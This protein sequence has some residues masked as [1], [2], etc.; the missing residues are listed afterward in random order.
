MKT[1]HQ[2]WEEIALLIT[3]FAG[4]T[5]PSAWKKSKIDAFLRDFHKKLAEICRQEPEKAALCGVAVV[6]GET[7]QY[8]RLSYFSFR[9]IFITKESLG[10]RST[11]EMF[12]IYL[13]FESANDFLTRKGIF[14]EPPP[15][16]EVKNARHFRKNQLGRWMLLAILLIIIL[17][18]L[19]TCT[20]CN[21]TPSYMFVR[22]ENG[23]VLVNL[24]TKK[25]V[26]LVKID[27]LIGIDYDS[28][29]RMF[30]WTDTKPWFQSIGC[31]KLNYTYTDTEAGTMNTRLSEG[32]DTPVGIALDFQKQI[33]YCGDYERRTVTAYDLKGKALPEVLDLT[34]DGK[35][36]SVELDGKNRV[37][38][39]TDVENNRIGRIF[40]DDGRIEPRFIQLGACYP[41]GLSVDTLHDKIYWTCQMATELG[42]SY[43]ASPQIHTIS[44]KHA[45]AAV[46]VDP[47]HGALYYCK[48]SGDTI[49]KA[50]LP[51]D[52][53]TT[54]SV[55][56]SV[57]LEG[58]IGLGVMKIVHGQ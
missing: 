21:S 42:W 27:K 51:D 1:L 26:Q 22:H 33:I 4:G 56:D 37:L 48:K 12:A 54:V 38:Y 39:W 30:Y 28:E 9:R 24:E 7:V 47:V 41:D 5:H 53:Q 34:I 15:M 3:G 36:S 23:I 49:Y 8:P 29:T 57:V 31:A 11:R 55:I 45:V 32:M 58:M 6:N 10:N 50:T 2:F 13:G 14:E 46:E 18:L 44:L 40:L 20:S 52:E 35:P 43:T 19:K 17:L 25:D 16:T